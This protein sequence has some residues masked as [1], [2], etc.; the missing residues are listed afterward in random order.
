MRR[1][2]L[3]LAAVFAATIASALP[4]RADWTTDPV[5][6]PEGLTT[7]WDRC[8]YWSMSKKS[9]GRMYPGERR[10]HI[11]ECVDAGGP[12]GMKSRRLKK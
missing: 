7:P 2:G 10:A 12:P 3:L 4:S 9:F 6:I 5:L 1:A 11:R 8:K